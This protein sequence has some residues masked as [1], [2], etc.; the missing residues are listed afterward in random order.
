MKKVWGR[1]DEGLFVGHCNS[2]EEG[3]L[4]VGD[5]LQDT[6]YLGRT[7]RMPYRLCQAGRPAGQ[8]EGGDDG[9]R[10]KGTRKRE[11]DRRSVERAFTLSR[12]RSHAQS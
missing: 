5:G 7:E 11:R 12:A 8:R 3:W 2:Q 10:G 4:V 1:A 9:Q 6:E